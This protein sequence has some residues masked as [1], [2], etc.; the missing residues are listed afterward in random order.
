MAIAQ[1]TLT[2]SIASIYTSTGVSAVTTMFF[3]N[4]SGATV[5]FSVLL[6]VGAGTGTLAA[7][8]ILKEISLIAGDTYIFNSEKIILDTGDQIQAVASAGSA[9]VTTIS[10]VGL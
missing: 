6:K 2:T 1:T 10:Y 9:V 5:T 4:N 3:L 8:G 7:N